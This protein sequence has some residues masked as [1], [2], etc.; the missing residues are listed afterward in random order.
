MARRRMFS[1]DVCDTDSFLDLP[2]S[3]QALYFHLGLRADDDGFVS[4]PKKIAKICNCSDDDLKLLIAKGYLIPF[5]SGVC[6]IVDW[7]INNFLRSDRY[8]ETLFLEEK[9]SLITSENRRYTVGIPDGYQRYPQDRIDKDRIENKKG[10]KRPA[11]SNFIRPSLEDVQTF[12]AEKGYQVDAEAFIAFYDSNGWKVGR[13]PMKSWKSAVVTW[14]KR[15]NS[16]QK[17][18]NAQSQANMH[19]TTNDKGETVWTLK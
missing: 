1:L 5:Q 9:S 4:A 14:S 13:N 17:P 7:K 10:A 8:R 11:R 3:T 19:L 2:V 15:E 18:E 6:V 12:I 16:T